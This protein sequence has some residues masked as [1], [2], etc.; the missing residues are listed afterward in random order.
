VSLLSSD[1]KAS[2]PANPFAQPKHQ[3]HT[4]SAPL[5]FI[6]PPKHSS[7]VLL[8]GQSGTFVCRHAFFWTSISS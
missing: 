6:P 4:P 2:T 8:F 5:S 3:F 1:V 7:R